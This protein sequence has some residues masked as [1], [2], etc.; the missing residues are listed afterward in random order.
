MF[1]VIVF[2]T[3]RVPF[4]SQIYSNF[5]MAKNPKEYFLLGGHN[6]GLSHRNIKHK[7]IVVVVEVVFFF[8]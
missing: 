2:G 4:C 6:C 8:D 5:Y 1:P 3:S 7:K